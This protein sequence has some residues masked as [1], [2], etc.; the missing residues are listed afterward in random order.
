MLSNKES[1]IIYIGRSDCK[2]CIEFTPILQ[3]YLDN[4]PGTYVYYVDV[5]QYRDSALEKDAS[6]QEVEFYNSIQE[7]LQYEWTPTLHFIMDGGII[8][9][10]EYLSVDYYLIEDRDTQ[11]LEKEKYISSFQEWM[12]KKFR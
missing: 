5:K 12:S 8:D 2:D 6:N 7:T 3:D 10:Y 1:F 11:V 9:T 4:N